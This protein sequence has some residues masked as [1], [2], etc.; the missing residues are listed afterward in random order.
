MQEAYHKQEEK[1]AKKL[2]S[3]LWSWQFL[4]LWLI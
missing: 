3:A 2:S 4:Q 1:K